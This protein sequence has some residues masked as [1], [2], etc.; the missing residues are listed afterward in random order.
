M[1]TKNLRVA[2]G[3]IAFDDR[4]GDGRP[5]V[6]LPGAGNVRAEYRFVAPALASDGSRVVTV[7]LRG[8]G[9]SSSSWPR[10]RDDRNGE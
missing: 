2:D 7:D 1:T 8:H 10:L 3:T 9:E 5:V 6:M 4:G